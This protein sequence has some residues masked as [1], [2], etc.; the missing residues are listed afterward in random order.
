MITENP[1]N[2]IMVTYTSISFLSSSYF[3]ILMYGD[4]SETKVMSFPA[5]FHYILIQEKKRKFIVHIWI[6]KHIHIPNI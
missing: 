5:T 4:C 2:G 3:Y 6:I 1:D